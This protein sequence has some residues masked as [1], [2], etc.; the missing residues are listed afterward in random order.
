LA[1]ISTGGITRVW[2]TKPDRFTLNS[3]HQMPGLNT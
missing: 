1:L 2:S 3:I